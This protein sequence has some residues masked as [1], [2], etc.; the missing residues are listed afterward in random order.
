M[1]TKL[2]FPTLTGSLMPTKADNAAALARTLAAAAE[3]NRAA[4]QIP[5]RSD[6]GSRL[7]AAVKARLRHRAATNTVTAEQEDFGQK[8]KEAIQRKTRKS[9]AQHKEQAERERNRYRHK[10]RPHTKGE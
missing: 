9:P 10:P 7:K 4:E 5:S 1:L 3:L 8:L 2:C 6:F